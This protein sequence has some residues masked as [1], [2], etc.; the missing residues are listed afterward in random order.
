MLLAM[1]ELKKKPFM[2]SM[3][4]LDWAGE[5]QKGKKKLGKYMGKWEIP[6]VPFTF[7]HKALYFQLS[8]QYM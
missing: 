5:I 3:L 7:H 6:C 4:G 1:L 8:L 2:S